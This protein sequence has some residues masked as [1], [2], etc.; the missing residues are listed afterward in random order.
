MKH[1]FCLIVFLFILAGCEGF[2]IKDK[3]FSIKTIHIF[4]YW[5]RRRLVILIPIH[6]IGIG[7]VC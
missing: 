1:K 5:L 3:E 4:R 6:T 2:F 7:L